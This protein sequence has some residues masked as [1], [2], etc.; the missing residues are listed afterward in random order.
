MQIKADKTLTCIFYCL[1]EVAITGIKYTGV[2]KH[3]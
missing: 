1:N 2:R 3:E